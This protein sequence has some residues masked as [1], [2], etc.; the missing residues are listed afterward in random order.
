MEVMVALVE[1]SDD[2]LASSVPISMQ[3]SIVERL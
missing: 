1:D 3:P 2:S